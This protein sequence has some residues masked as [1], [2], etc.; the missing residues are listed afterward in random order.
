MTLAESELPVNLLVEILIKNQVKQALAVRRDDTPSANRYMKKVNQARHALA[1][2]GNS[3]RAAL[4]GLMRHPMPQ[5]RLDGAVSVMQWA[6]DLAIPVLGRLIAETGYEKDM[7]ADELIEVRHE[8]TLS[9]FDHF[10]TKYY[11]RDELIEP[12][13][14]Y[15]VDI[16]S[17]K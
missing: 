3:G 16:P 17:L 4:E 11:D 15:G 2:K 6:P 10:G 12:L 14:A 13:R 7:S 1:A 8:A 9:L 5:V